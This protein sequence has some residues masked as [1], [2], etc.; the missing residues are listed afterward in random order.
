MTHLTHHFVSHCVTART[1][2]ISRRATVRFSYVT[3]IP[4][5]RSIAVPISHAALF[6]VMR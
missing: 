1:I 4:A 5:V 3:S 6:A 2:L